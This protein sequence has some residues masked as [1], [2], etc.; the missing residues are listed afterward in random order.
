MV[1]CSIYKTSTKRKD[2]YTNMHAR[3]GITS[4]VQNKIIKSE[5]AS[6]DKISVLLIGIDSISRLNLIRTM[7]QTV[8]FLKNQGWLDLK[9]YNKMDDNTFPNLMAI[10]TGQSPKQIRSSKG[11]FPSNRH[12]VDNCSFIWK[13]YANEGYITAYGE[14]EPSIGTFNYHKSGFYQ[15]PTDY[16]LRPFMLAAEKFMKVKKKDNLNLCLGPTATSDHILQYA[17]DLA[18]KLKN[19]LYFGLFWMNSFSHNNVNSPSSMD[20]RILQFFNNLTESGALNNTFIVFLSDH[21]MRFGKIRETFIGWLEE[22]LPFIYMWVPE[23]YRE[24]YPQK[25]NNFIEN[26]DR[27][28]SPYDLHLTL[29]DVL[30]NNHTNG[31]A[32]CPKCFSLFDE[33]PWN[34]SCVDV[35]ITE[36]WCTCSEY[37]TLSTEGQSVK[38]MV[39]FALNEINKIVLNGTNFTV[40]NKKCA[41]LSVKRILSVRSKLFER[42]L[43]YDEYIVLFETL[44]G[45]ALF[46]ATIRHSHNF[47]LLDTVSRINAFGIQS[48]C[49]HDAY[50]KKYCYCVNS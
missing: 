21:G 2:V 39:K 47:Q 37:R 18:T 12:S 45:E 27:L 3:I 41:T 11:C 46:E 22:R 5:T 23:W 31:S 6:K 1:K 44:P 34:R 8:S 32:A 13:D 33:V 49:M 40:N 36:H 29:Q 17:L 43:G 4:Q 16:Y 14:D 38:A 48:K 26:R 35:G 20:L 19:T 7:P 50:L 25:F 9:G 28:T 24:K 10:L 15:S 30:Y 42:K